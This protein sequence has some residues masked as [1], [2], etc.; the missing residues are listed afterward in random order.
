MTASPAE[1]AAME[2]AVALAAAARGRTSPNPTVGC[3]VLDAAGRVAGEGYHAGAGTPHAEV[4]ALADAGARARGGTAVV[5][6]EPCRHWGRTGP[7]SEALLAAGIRRVV[8]ALDDPTAQARGGARQLR[9]AGVEAVGGVLG[10]AAFAANEHWLEAVRLGR[11]FVTWKAGTSLDGRS[12]AADG[13]SRWITG[14]E[15]RA[16]VHAL[17]A[18]HDAVLVGAGTVRADDPQLGVRHVEG[19][20]PLRVLL[21]SDGAVPPAA[22]AFDAAA[23]TL[24][25]AAEDAACSLPE[26]VALAWVPRAPGGGLEL[27]ALLRVLEARGVRSLLLEGGAELAA[28]FVR[29]GFVDRIVAYVAPVLLGAAGR[30]ALGDL[31]VA[32]L[33][34]AP[35]ARF[36]S[37]RAVGADVR[38]ALRCSGAPLERIG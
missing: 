36:E 6:L 18:E 17:R 29:A 32:S 13:S 12:A 19:A 26:H 27:P 8:Y 2:R 20:P 11:P 1:L 9:A 24:V 10:E 22:R 25:V 28:S 23:P 30:P 5:T 14:R 15:A 31:G 35:R 16:E 34:A 37:A 7:C 21:V 33:D 3:V 4:V 38:L